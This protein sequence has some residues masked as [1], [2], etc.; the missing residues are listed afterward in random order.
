MF[1]QEIGCVLEKMFK[2]RGMFNTAG[3]FSVIIAEFK[4][5]VPKM[6]KNTTLILEKQQQNTSILTQV[7]RRPL[8]KSLQ[9]LQEPERVSAIWIKNLGS[10]VNKINNA[11]LSMVV[12]NPKDATKLDIVR[13][14]KTYS[15]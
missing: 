1:H 10:F 6:F 12:M 15:G 4:S 8:T 14:D 5:D 2:K 7:L 9:E 11:K 3:Y 13:L